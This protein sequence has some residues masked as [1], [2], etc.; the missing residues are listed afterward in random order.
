MNRH[1]RTS[2]LV[3]HLRLLASIFLLLTISSVAQQ[4]NSDMRA[5]CEANNINDPLNAP[6]GMQIAIPR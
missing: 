2:A 6:V 3:P 4:N 1:E 5:I